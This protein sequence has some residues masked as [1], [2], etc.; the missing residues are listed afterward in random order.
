MVQV[1]CAF[2]TFYRVGSIDTPTL[3]CFLV[4]LADA[5]CSIWLAVSLKGEI[6]FPVRF[7]HFACAIG[8]RRYKFHAQQWQQRN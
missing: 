1:P 8:N 7:V 4:C 6:T 2:S 5:C 3:L